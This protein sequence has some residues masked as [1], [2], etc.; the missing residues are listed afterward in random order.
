[1]FKFS[2]SAVLPIVALLA[3][4]AAPAQAVEVISN[5]NFESGLTG[6]T[7]YITAHGTISQIPGYSGGTPDLPAVKS[8]NTTG[9]GAS[10]AL[11][12]NAGANPSSATPEGGGV[13]QTFTTT[14]GI[15]TFSAN[16][17]NQWLSQSA[18][19]ASIGL[20]SVL[21][22]GVVMDSHDF[23]IVT[24]NPTGWT[25]LSTLNFTTN[26]SAGEHTLAL[27]VTRMY[28][29]ALGV[30]AEYF[31]NVSLNVTSAVPEPSTWA[32]MILGFAGVGFLAYRR[33]KGATLAA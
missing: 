26:L 23:G 12:L 5:G 1:M 22:D 28:A 25:F 4:S 33:R 14:G 3:V 6:W 20:F 17:A 13:T 7:G 2:R 19:I 9:S 30:D 27:Q 24:A 10:N 29:P 8:F 32:M 31:D 21:L 15:A 11:A 16:I 18:S